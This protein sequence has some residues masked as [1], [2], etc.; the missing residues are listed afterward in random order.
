MRDRR[1]RGGRWRWGRRRGIKNSWRQWSGLWMFSSSS[2][3]AISNKTLSSTTR[4]TWFSTNSNTWRSSTAHYYRLF[5]WATT[6]KT[7]QTFRTA[8]TV[9]T[10]ATVATADT[11]NTERKETRGRRRR[12]DWRMGSRVAD[13]IELSGDGRWRWRSSS[14]WCCCWCCDFDHVNARIICNDITRFWFPSRLFL[15]CDVILLDQI[16]VWCFV[17][18]LDLW[19]WT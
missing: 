9:I 4:C 6:G 15:H 10:V 13:W 16:S 7:V 17:G 5:H 2:V 8:V 14:F 11:D 19:C 18:W 1:G 12:S 3:S